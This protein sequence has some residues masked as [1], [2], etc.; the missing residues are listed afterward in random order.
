MAHEYFSVYHQL[1]LSC[2]IYLEKL[3]SSFRPILLC[4]PS[5]LSSVHIVLSIFENEWMISLSLPRAFNSAV[6]T[7]AHSTSFPMSY[8][9]INLI[10]YDNCLGRSIYS[11]AT[12]N[13]LLV[14]RFQLKLGTVM[15][16]IVSVD[17][18][19]VQKILSNSYYFLFS[20]V[21]NWSA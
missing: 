21:N 2:N 17:L 1:A 19:Y 20:L 3:S 10:V 16:S 15:L 6:S 12:T 13:S 5:F 18:I 8:T 14:F 9:S 7:S 11:Q 4:S